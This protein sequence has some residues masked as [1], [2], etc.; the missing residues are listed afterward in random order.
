MSFYRGFE[1]RAEEKPKLR[2]TLLAGYVSPSMAG[3]A[4]MGPVALLNRLESSIP[5]SEV[6]KF[7]K[8]INKSR[9]LKTKV[10]EL[11][12]STGARILGSSGEYRPGV[13]TIALTRNANLSTAA[14]E[15]GHASMMPLLIKD[16]SLN[17]LVDL[18]RKGSF[19]A[20]VL[21]TP[22]ALYSEG[23]IQ[24]AAPY[25]APIAASPLVAEE[26]I[27][28]IRGVKDIAKHY[29]T[30]KA[31]K[32]VPSLLAALGTY[33]AIPAASYYYSKKYLEKRKKGKK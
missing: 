27:A 25:I 2:D 33:A 28:S 7:V 1:K 13:D 23:D 16:K 21:G 15:M 30:T 22:L 26:A 18:S 4:A 5:F 17:R 32:A 8:K 10:T 29:G 24:K 9:G 19:A 12:M 6:K 11:P 3:I 20:G 14:H 31:I